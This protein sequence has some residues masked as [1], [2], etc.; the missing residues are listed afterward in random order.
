MF[1]GSWASLIFSLCS[2]G[3]GPAN[4]WVWGF[5]REGAGETR[6][7]WVQKLYVRS[8]QERVEARK[9]S[10]KVNG[11]ESGE[12]RTT[13]YGKGPG[14]KRKIQYK[15]PIKQVRWKNDIWWG[16]NCIISESESCF[17]SHNF[18][19][20]CVFFASLLLGLFYV[21]EF[22]VIQVK[23]NSLL[24]TKTWLPLVTFHLLSKRLLQF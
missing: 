14:W 24:K 3:P 17:M 21:D 5:S 4:W 23:D 6:V 13:G 20:L 8:E 16:K 11:E 18:L 1:I 2:Y 10:R 19:P 15:L 7:T 9:E 12:H 22:S